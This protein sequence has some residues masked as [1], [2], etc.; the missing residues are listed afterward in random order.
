MRYPVIPCRD[1]A[2]PVVMLVSAAAVVDGT[3]VVIAAP[4]IAPTTG[5]RPGEATT[6]HPSPS[7]TRS[8]VARAPATA[9]GRKSTGRSP[10]SAGTTFVT[11]APA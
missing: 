5:I 4:P 1:G 8:T 11:L 2:T 10:S 9:V 7:S 6:S 3:T